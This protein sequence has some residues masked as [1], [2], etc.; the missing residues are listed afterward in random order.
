MFFGGVEKKKNI[1]LTAM[2]VEIG[3]LVPG[4]GPG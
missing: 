2:L 1:V 4:A 3:R